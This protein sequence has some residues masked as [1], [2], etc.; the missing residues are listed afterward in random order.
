MMIN[1]T[2]AIAPSEVRIIDGKTLLTG[3]FNFIKAAQ[4]KKAGS[5]LILRDAALVAPDV[6]NGGAQRQHSYPYVGGGAVR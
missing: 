1:A 5:Q 2:H 4:N 3:R 6:K